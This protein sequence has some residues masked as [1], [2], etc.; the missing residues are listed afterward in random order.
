MPITLTHKDQTPFLNDEPFISKC[1]NS[2]FVDLLF[3]MLSER[4][5]S[6]DEGKLLE[7]VMK[8]SIDH[9]PDTPSA[10]AVI[11][12]AES[13]NSVS[14][15]LSRGVEKIDDSHGGAGENAMKM[16]Y[17]I[18]KDGLDTIN[19]VKEHLSAE[20]RVPGFGHR[21]YDKDIRAEEILN[22]M[23]RVKIGVEYVEIARKIESALRELTSKTLPI[24]IDGAHAVAFCAF[25]FDP[26]LAKP[27]FIISRIPGLSA[28]YLNNKK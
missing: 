5:P 18:K 13:G 1:E 20:T 3:E 12:N 28:H 26:S 19:I 8:L 21:L 24:N 9:G 23:V 6:K 10:C 22:E 27:I 25:G 7:L 14:V 17:R 15:A 16:F 2:S 4:R 11:E